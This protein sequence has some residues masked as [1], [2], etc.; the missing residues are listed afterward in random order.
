MKPVIFL[1]AA[2][3]AFGQSL[4]TVKVAAGQASRASKLPAELRPFLEVALQ[5]R[6]NGFVES[7]DVDR[8]SVVKK[9][10]VIVK[11]SA[12]ELAALWPP[13]GSWVTSV[14]SRLPKW[15]NSHRRS[16]SW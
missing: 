2:A 11:L 13:A 1:L 10:Q 16:P 6:V 7:I 8:G 15:P 5:A 9:G 3:A 12:P 4:E 14:S